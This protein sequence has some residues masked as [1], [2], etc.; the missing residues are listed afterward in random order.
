MTGPQYGARHQRSR[1]PRAW[2]F[3]TAGLAAVTAG[4]V[5][6]GILLTGG[7][8]TGRRPAPLATNVTS[9]QAIG[10]AN[11]GQVSADGAVV[12]IGTLLTDS[13][14]GLAFT[15][16]T[17]GQIVQ[18]S[19][20]WQADQM[21]GG[22]FILVFTPNGRCLSSSRTKQGATVQ[23]VH[24]HLGLNE[25]WYHPYLGTDRS[26]RNYWQLRSAANGQCLAVGGTQVGGGVD[27]VVRPCSH[28]MPWQQL[29][30]FWT[31]F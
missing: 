22:A 7:T 23:L 31:A 8:S 30:A 4:A 21:G 14:G 10:L 26:G 1:G 28:S 20:Q 29:I 16:S 6:A 27:V 24:C 15:S 25:R 18:P 9:T 19:Q 5:V 2:V 17:R 13:P 12:G 11:P 3:G